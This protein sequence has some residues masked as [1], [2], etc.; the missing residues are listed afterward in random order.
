MYFAF[1]P[2]DASADRGDTTV[3]RPSVCLSVCND[4]V[5]YSHRLEF[6]ENN[7]TAKYL[8]VHVLVDARHGRSGATGTP[9]KLGWNIGCELE[10]NYKGD[11][12]RLLIYVLRRE[13]PRL[14]LQPKRP[15]AGYAH[16]TAVSRGIPNL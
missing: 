11:K 8:K 9:P 10:L 7:F 3:S 2:R 13:I 1:L 15:A 14:A 4:Q 5:P 12:A 16:V 6:F